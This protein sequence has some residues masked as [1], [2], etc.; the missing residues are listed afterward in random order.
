MI[1]S[2]PAYGN[3]QVYG[4]FPCANEKSLYVNDTFKSMEEKPY[5]RIGYLRLFFYS[6]VEKGGMYIKSIYCPFHIIMVATFIN[7]VVQ[8]KLWLWQP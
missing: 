4:K 8:T 1:F 2:I 7:M 5:F 3:T 6:V